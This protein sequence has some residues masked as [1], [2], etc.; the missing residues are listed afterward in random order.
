MKKRLDKHLARTT[1]MIPLAEKRALDQMASDNGRS[2]A[3][4]VRIAIHNH[5]KKQGRIA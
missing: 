3:S 4:E 2:E 1:A 5:L